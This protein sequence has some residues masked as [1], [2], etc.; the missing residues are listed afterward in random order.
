MAPHY[1]V[2]IIT[3]VLSVVRWFLELY[4]MVNVGYASLV[5]SSPV[6]W[7]PQINTTR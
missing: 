2:R 7:G 6:Q 1:P 5:L 3:N 4:P